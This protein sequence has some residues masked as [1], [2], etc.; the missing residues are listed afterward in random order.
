MMK[1]YMITGTFHRGKKSEGDSTRK[2]DAPFPKEKAVLLIYGGSAPPPHI[3]WCKLKLTGRAI[4]II[5][6][7][8]SEYICWSKSL[9]TLDQTNHSDSIPKLGRFPL[10]VDPLVGMT[11]LTKALMD[12]GNGLNLMSL[13]TFEGMGLAHD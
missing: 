11:R 9:I 8:V 13:D 3:S 10:I 7:V 12:G 1:N 2:V 5:G 6:L 4:N